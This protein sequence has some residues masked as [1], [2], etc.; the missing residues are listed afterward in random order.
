MVGLAVDHDLILTVHHP[1][2]ASNIAQ[3]ALGNLSVFLK[4]NVGLQRLGLDP[5]DIEPAIRALQQNPK[6]AIDGVYTH[7][8]V[9]DEP[10]TAPAIGY[11][12]RVFIEAVGVAKRLGVKA[13]YT[14]VASSAVLRHTDKM[15][16][17]AVDPG[18]LLYG[19][20]HSGLETEIPVEPVLRA[21]R[22][23]LISVRR[24]GDGDALLPLGL[25]PGWRIGVVPLGLRDGLPGFTAGHVLVN[26]R[27]A[28]IIGPSSLEHTR[29]DLGDALDAQVGDEVVVLG[30]Q[31]ERKI[32]IDDIMRTCG[33]GRAVELTMAISPDVPRIAVGR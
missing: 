32:T 1:S 18:H 8:F 5:D 4:I 6:V 3:L 25:R 22:S 16:L 23:R 33:Y 29:V 12:F 19:F 21:I 24:I 7:M 27:T 10:D 26:A 30:E 2:I 11:Q 17:T 31:G 28:P 20:G 9:P 14:M 15:N 13:A